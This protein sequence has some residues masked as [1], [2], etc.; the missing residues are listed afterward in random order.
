MRRVLEVTHIYIVYYPLPGTAS[1]MP[2]SLTNIRTRSGRKSLVKMDS[3][4]TIMISKLSL[5]V[6]D[7]MYDSHCRPVIFT[8]FG[9]GPCCDA[10]AIMGGATI[11]LLNCEQRNEMMDRS[12]MSSRAQRILD[13]NSLDR[14][15]YLLTFVFQVNSCDQESS[16]KQQKRHQGFT[17]TLHDRR[18]P[19]L[20]MK[21]LVKQCRQKAV[22]QSLKTIW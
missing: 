22:D 13:P 9:H 18:G 21:C 8:H 17:S 3:S 7:A 19:L 10:M 2:S 6:D 20:Q 4:A 16:S 15:A 5:V 12:R 14:D 1:T 11:E